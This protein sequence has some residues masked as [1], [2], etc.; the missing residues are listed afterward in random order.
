[1]IDDY[2]EE[3]VDVNVYRFRELQFQQR[4]FIEMAEQYDCERVSLCF[5]GAS[6]P[7]NPVMRLSFETIILMIMKFTDNNQMRT[8]PLTIN[9][10]TAQHGMN[11]YSCSR[12]RFTAG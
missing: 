10:C 1:M 5:N 8:N 2:D 12:T 6:A 3:D 9:K 4:I 7:T 11:A